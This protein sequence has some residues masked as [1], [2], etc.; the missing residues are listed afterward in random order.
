[1]C[2]YFNEKSEYEEE[3]PFQN[4]VEN[5]STNPRTRDGEYIIHIPEL[6]IIVTHTLAERVGCTGFSD[7]V[8]SVEII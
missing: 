6:I 7:N 8:V 1:M 5:I 2:I 3:E 4:K